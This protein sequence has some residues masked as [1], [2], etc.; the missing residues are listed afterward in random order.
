[1]EKWYSVAELAEVTGISEPTLRRYLLTFKLY[2]VSTGGKRARK[3]DPA[4]VKL[5]SRVKSL[6]DSGYETDG[7][8]E[9]IRNEFPLIISDKEKAEMERN[10]DT[11]S[12]ATSEDVIRLEKT[13]EELKNIILEERA[14]REEL[15]EA[16]RQLLA[17]TNRNQK[18]SIEQESQLLLKSN[19][20]NQQKENKA[21]EEKPDQ[22][23]RKRFWQIF[24]K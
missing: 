21:V 6:Y 7:I 8:K 2:V 13:V 12:L 11:P 16:V 5:L 18:E 1:M 4:T 15:R 14:E 24:S 23:K 22:P 9:L 19:E 10:I 17:A 20:E 3:Y